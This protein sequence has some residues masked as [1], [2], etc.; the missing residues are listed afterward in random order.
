MLFEIRR[1]V[2]TQEFADFSK[3]TLSARARERKK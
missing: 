3:D 1:P 2:K